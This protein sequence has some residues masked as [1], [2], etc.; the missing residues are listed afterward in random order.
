MD[1]G[2]YIYIAPDV[3]IFFSPQ[4]V[5]KLIWTRNLAR[6]SELCAN[7]MVKLSEVHWKYRNTSSLVIV[8][9]GYITKEL[10]HQYTP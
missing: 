6:K 9:V 8:V 1:Q 2:V 3:A 10:I 4:K 5:C 7:N